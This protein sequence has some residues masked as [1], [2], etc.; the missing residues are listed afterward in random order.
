M[1]G[2]RRRRS[3]ETKQVFYPSKDGTK[4]PMFLV[5]K[6][7]LKL[8]GNNP[9]LLYAYGGFNVVQSPTFSASRLALLEQ[10]VVY[11]S[12]NLRGGGEYGEAWHEQGM[13]LKKQNVFDDFIAAAEWLIANKYTS[14][15]K[16]AIQGGSNG[17][18][19]VGAVMNQ[20]PELFGVALP[21]GRRHGHAAL[22]QVHDRLELDRRLRLQ[23]QRRRSSRRST[24]TRRCT[25]SRRARSIRRR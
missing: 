12:A 21:A 8:D 5:H 1:P 17:G 18:L 6:K 2:L 10:G 24:P 4:I 9:T 13:K 22:P 25:T 14:T 3:Y 23:R 20:R 11:A 7:G 16:L 19:L 15:P